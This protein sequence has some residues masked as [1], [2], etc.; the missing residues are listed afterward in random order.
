ML[1]EDIRIFNTIN[2]KVRKVH[3]CYRC[4]RG[5]QINEFAS[6]STLA[7]NGHIGNAYLCAECSEKV[8][9]KK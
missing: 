9:R 1:D 8:R 4:Q 3:D 7:Y 5:I 2:V 6:R